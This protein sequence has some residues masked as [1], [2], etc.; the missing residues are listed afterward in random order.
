MQPDHDHDGR[1]CDGVVWEPEPRCT[2]TG[3]RVGTAG[4]APVQTRELPVRF[5]LFEL[6]ARVEAR[7]R[8]RYPTLSRRP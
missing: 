4:R 2:T 8:R 3:H 7:L 5:W 6:A 1:P